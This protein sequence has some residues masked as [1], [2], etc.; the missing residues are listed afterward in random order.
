MDESQITSCRVCAGKIAVEAV[1]C[2][3]CGAPSKQDSIAT[4]QSKE[5]NKRGIYIIFIGG[6]SS[7]GGFVA[8]VLQPLAPILS[9][10]LICTGIIAVLMSCLWPWVGI[11][12][13][14][15]TGFFWCWT[16]VCGVFLG[17]Q[18]VI[19]PEGEDIGVVATYVPVVST[20]QNQLFDLKAG[21]D[22]LKAGQNDLKA[23]QDDLKAGQNDLNDG[24]SIVDARIESLM[25]LV[26]HSGNTNKRGATEANKIV[27]VASE[28]PVASHT[29]IQEFT[30]SDN[31]TI[32]E[33][34][35]QAIAL[36]NE[37]DA[38]ASDGNIEKALA[39]YRQSLA[40]FRKLSSL[41]DE[42]YRINLIYALGRNAWYEWFNGIE[43]TGYELALEA[44][45]LSKQ[46]YE[47]NNSSRS[48]ED[49]VISS[50]RLGYFLAWRGDNQRARPNLERSIIF[51]KFLLET[52]PSYKPNAIFFL[53][54]L[55]RLAELEYKEGNFERSREL[56]Y[57]VLDLSL[58]L[59]EEAGVGIDFAKNE[60]VLEYESSSLSKLANIELELLGDENFDFDS[61][62]MRT[63][64]ANQFMRAA[65]IRRELLAPS[66]I[67]G[68]AYLAIDLYLWTNSLGLGV[69][70][71]EQCDMYAEVISLCNE[72]EGTD[73]EQRV[74]YYKAS[75]M[76]LSC[77]TCSMSGDEEFNNC[78]IDAIDTMR[79]AAENPSPESSATWED[80]L[81]MEEFAIGWY[82]Q[83]QEYSPNYNEY[84][85]N[86]YENLPEIG[87]RDPALIDKIKQIQS[88]LSVFE[89]PKPNDPPWLIISILFGGC[90]VALIGAIAIGLVFFKLK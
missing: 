23:G 42:N 86:L 59:S 50:G 14:R 87:Q 54:D 78:Q 39:G 19:G 64:A 61:K 2:P 11:T 6:I 90:G 5:S 32:N 51:H 48:M 81:Y 34:L 49:I 8:D 80:L 89:M 29:Y 7:V 41:D 65:S 10:L 85:N 52:E 25:E 66:D 73:Q 13:R 67:I 27:N 15:I 75:A 24:L 43:S 56:Y 12:G 79:A 22:D 44:C 3:H 16:V 72:L 47:I 77:F 71:V 46:Q 82:L 53:Q 83:S 26:K 40:S 38:D 17:M 31:E 70:L 84:F 45:E 30:T 63:V 9:T 60:R 18:E 68:R 76:F 55:S 74:E 36:L 28:M 20:I 57:E 1:A 37:A 88:D 35:D 33:Q 69:R 58:I 4:V 21:Q 62:E